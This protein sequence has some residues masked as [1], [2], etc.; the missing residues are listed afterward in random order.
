MQDIFKRGRNE[1]MKAGSIH[2]VRLTLTRNLNRENQE[3][4]LFDTGRYSNLLDS[5]ANGGEQDRLPSHTDRLVMT[6]YVRHQ[7]MCISL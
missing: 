7:K 6:Y 2:D 3:E 4:L 1:L 5:G